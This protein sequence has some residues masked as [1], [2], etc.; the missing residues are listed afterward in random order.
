MNNLKKVGLTALG[1]ALVTVGSAQ[2]AEWSVSGGTSLNFNGQDNDMGN[3]WTMTDSV[4]F[5]SSGA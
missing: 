3:V 5:S 1:T 4:T 2:A